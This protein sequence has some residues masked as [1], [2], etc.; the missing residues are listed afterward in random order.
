M[1]E[2]NEKLIY[3][4]HPTSIDIVNGPG[5][6]DI[7]GDQGRG[8]EPS[9]VFA[10]AVF[11]IAE[12]EE[13]LALDVDAE[14][15]LQLLSKAFIGEGLGPAICMVDDNDLSCA[16]LLLGDNQGPDRV[17]SDPPTGIPQ[18]MGVT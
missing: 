17:I 13:V 12:G 11:H 9:D 14:V 16:E 4:L 15:S 3:L 10:D 8:F 18:D 7:I 5:N 2:S 1:K 6:D